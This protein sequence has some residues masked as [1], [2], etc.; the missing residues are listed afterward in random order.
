[1][2]KRT[3]LMANF[4]SYDKLPEGN[5]SKVMISTHMDCRLDWWLISATKM[6]DII[7]DAGSYCVAT[8]VD[9]L[10]HQSGLAGS[11][12]LWI[13]WYPIVTGRI[14]QLFVVTPIVTPIKLH[15]I[16]CS[17][18]FPI[19]HMGYEWVFPTNKKISKIKH[20]HTQTTVLFT[21]R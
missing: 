17:W 3:I 14:S 11:R 8:H 7:G 13:T 10:N 21:H 9:G 5:S 6:V 12:H 1:M 20:S 19:N 15:Q 4:N 18:V 16:A 2:G